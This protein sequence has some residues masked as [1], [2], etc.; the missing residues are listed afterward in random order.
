[1][2]LCTAHRRYYVM[3]NYVTDGLGTEE[4]SCGG[5]SINIAKATEVS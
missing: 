4:T 1:M 3:F 5:T 2:T